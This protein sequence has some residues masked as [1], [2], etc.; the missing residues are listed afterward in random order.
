M[1]HSSKRQSLASHKGEGKRY[2]LQWQ[3]WGSQGSAE[4]QPEGATAFASNL[5]LCGGKRGELQECMRKG[6]HGQAWAVCMA[7]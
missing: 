5:L 3:T 4:L 6:K 2:P 7:L 1:L